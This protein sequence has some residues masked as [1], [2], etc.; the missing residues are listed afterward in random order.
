MSVNLR[1]LASLLQPD[2]LILAGS[3][4]AARPH[5]ASSFDLDP[6]P[7]PP[8]THIDGQEFRD[9][10]LSAIQ[11]GKGLHIRASTHSKLR[12]VAT[13]IATLVS[14]QDVAGSDDAD[15][16]PMLPGYEVDSRQVT[17]GTRDLDFCIVHLVNGKIRGVEVKGFTADALRDILDSYLN[18][19]TH[20]RSD[21][22]QKKG[23]PDYSGRLNRRFEQ[24]EA[25]RAHTGVNP[26]LVL[27][28]DVDDNDLDDIRMIVHTLF[29]YRIHIARVSEVKIVEVRDRLRSGLG[30]PDGQS[31]NGSAGPGN[32]SAGPGNGSTGP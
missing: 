6:E 21:T 26:V 19:P 4:G 30:F 28:S 5:C 8:A 3:I 11:A 23:S 25:A 10:A 17:M 22:A 9:S 32:G 18:I 20:L 12:G 15:S 29:K 1:H 31:G 16:R 27:S 14:A 13:E 2:E 7:V 24:L